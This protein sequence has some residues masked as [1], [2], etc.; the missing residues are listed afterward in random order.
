MRIIPAID[1]LNGKCVRLRKG[2]YSTQTIYSE[3]PLEVALSMEA[4]GI[5]YLHVVD[6]DGARSMHV[7]NHKML[8]ILATKTKLKI[9][10]GGGIKSKEDIAIAFDCGAS[11]VTAGSIAVGHPEIVA[12]WLA[13]YGAARIILGADC[14]DRMV[15]THGWAKKSELDVVSFIAAYAQKGIQD[16]IC[17]DIEMDGMLKGPS[18][19]LYKEIIQKTTVNLIASGGITSLADL[20]QLKEMGCSGAII[21]KA[22]YENKISLKE[23]NQLC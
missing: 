22:I 9:D 20:R 12:E 16:V 2:A 21:G 15:A 11:Q 3:S 10:F 8:E 17:T 14:Q 19:L 18:V 6:L 4:N 23:L 1:I 7:V 5:Q 13:E